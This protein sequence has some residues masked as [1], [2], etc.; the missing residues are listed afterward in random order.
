[1]NRLTNSF[2]GPSKV[3]LILFVLAGIGPPLRAQSPSEKWGD[4]LTHHPDRARVIREFM[5]DAGPA[6]IAVALPSGATNTKRSYCFDADECRIRYAWTGGFI[7]ISYAK[8]DGPASVI[9]EVFYNARAGLPLRF[10][11]RSNIVPEEERS[12]LGYRLVEGVPE[13]RYRVEGHLIRHRIVQPEDGTGL[14]EQ[15]RIKNVSKPVWVATVPEPGLSFTASKGTWHGN[16]LKLTPSEA[17]SFSVH[18]QRSTGKES[19]AS[20][21]SSDDEEQ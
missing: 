19:S 12:F 16:D 15:Y 14:I 10:G 11:D 21:S 4:P 5:P 8:K 2:S 1:M 6:S 13:F 3:L 18:I 17:A 7:D 20:P 9:G